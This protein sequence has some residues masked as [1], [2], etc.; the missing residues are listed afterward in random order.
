MCVINLLLTVFS[1]PLTVRVILVLKESFSS[2]NPPERSDLL[3]LLVSSCI[4]L[5]PE[6]EGTNLSFYSIWFISRS[7]KN[8]SQMG[9]STH[10]FLTKSKTI[11]QGKHNSYAENVS[12]F[13]SSLI[14]LL[15][16]KIIIQKS[17]WDYQSFK[18]KYIKNFRLD[19]RIP[20]N[21]ESTLY[22]DVKRVY[23]RRKTR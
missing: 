19:Y 20:V 14:C 12:V 10:S 3:P 22:Q 4:L 16:N 6:F 18:K 2:P 5:K 21:I 8:G 17:D 15:G 7:Q 23:R 9:L 1:E 11:R 13:V